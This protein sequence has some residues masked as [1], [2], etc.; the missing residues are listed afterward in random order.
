MAGCSVANLVD[1]LF[2]RVQRG[3]VAN[4]AIRAIKVVVDRSG[5]SDT[6]E[7]VFFSQLQRAAQR[8]ITADNDECID[9][10][11]LQGFIGLSATFRCRKSLAASRA[12]DRAATL[13]D[14]ADI[15]C[16]KRR[17]IAIDQS[18]ITT[19]NAFD[20]KTIY[21]ATARHGADGSIHSG[22]IAA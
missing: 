20:L 11:A 12:Q 1:T 10:F 19:I 15:F 18:V 5:Q 2:D 6:R 3:V 16:G 22:C 7:V 9:I 21:N 13:Y 14:V 4:R 17:N 8:T